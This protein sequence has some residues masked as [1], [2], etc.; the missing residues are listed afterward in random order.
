MIPDG[1]RRQGAQSG[2]VER[3]REPIAPRYQHIVRVFV[4]GD[5]RRRRHRW[6]EGACPGQHV[7]QV[8]QGCEIPL[9]NGEHRGSGSSAIEY[10][11]HV[12]PSR[13]RSARKG[14]TSHPSSAGEARV[15]AMS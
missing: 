1:D 10:F 11:R 15:L 5:H 4:L 7:A 2:D 8:S 14:A 9:E 13:S 12:P 3:E 6:I